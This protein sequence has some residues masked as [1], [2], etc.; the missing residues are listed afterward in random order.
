LGRR[1]VRPGHFGGMQSI[2]KSDRLLLA[3]SRCYND[4]TEKH[5]CR[6]F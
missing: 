1:T 6:S 4:D 2:A 5:S 3:V